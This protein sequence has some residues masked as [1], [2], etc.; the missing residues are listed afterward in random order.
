MALMA[1]IASV[2][3][4]SQTPRGLLEEV[5]MIPPA[6]LAP[7]GRGPLGNTLHTEIVT[8]SLHGIARVYL[9]DIY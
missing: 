8:A 4:P 7:Q 2:F 6:F 9:G 3:P 1:L 5:A